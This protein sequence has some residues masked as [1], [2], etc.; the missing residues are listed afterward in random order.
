ML[1]CTL[2]S[3]N[4]AERARR[5]AG[6]ARSY[7]MLGFSL[8]VCGMHGLARWY[9]ARGLAVAEQHRDLPGRVFVGYSRGVYLIGVGQWEAS[10]RASEQGAIA[11]GEL[12][13][14]QESEMIEAALA[15]LEYYTGD[16]T[17]A[18]VRYR[19]LWEAARERGNA[20][21]EAWGLYGE[22]RSLVLQGE[23]ARAEEGLR[24]ALSIFAE[25]PEEVSE[26]ICHGLLAT[27][28]LDRGDLD[29]ATIHARAAMQLIRRAPPTVVTAL[30]GYAGVAR[31][32][33]ARLAASPARTIRDPC[34]QEAVEAVR[35][36]R[37]YALFF[38]IGRPRARLMSGC[39]LSLMGHRH[40]A[41]QRYRSALTLANGLG[42]PYEVALSH[43]HIAA[44]N[45][46]GSHE[47]AEHLGQMHTLLER[48]N[49]SVPST[50]LKNEREG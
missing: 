47:R 18:R 5:I 36:L 8:G 49:A 3:L 28:C 43:A 27:C 50:T 38:P 21:H 1:A 2:L 7:A 40:R 30:E 24:N 48:M 16:L 33:L 14:P 15:N 35:Q 23:V 42:L 19:T 6:T 20:Q 10:R 9:F 37:R 31:V 4:A 11:A 39:L 25:N 34:Y 44:T 26:L 41:Q 46:P 29:E 17:A 32:A 12:G 45:A 22:A 13:D